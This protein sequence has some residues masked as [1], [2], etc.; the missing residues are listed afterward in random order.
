MDDPRYP[1]G[2][3]QAP[4]TIDAEMRRDHLERIESL[5]L[6]LRNAVVGLDDA[7]L[8]TPY[9]EGGWTLRQVVHHVADSHMNA[10]TRHKLALTEE[11]PT[12]RPYDQ[13]RWAEL[14]DA[15]TAPIGM[16]LAMLDAIHARWT[17]ML[18]ALAPEHFERR[19]HH[20]EMGKTIS[21]DVNLA[22]YA[23]H[24]AHHVAHIN[25]LRE[26]KGW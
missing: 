21:L 14:P 20:P 12:I 24:G 4:A 23:W 3:F 16:S 18:R 10:F 2:T 7:Q 6:D 22:L 17:H 19:F 1:I 25:R 8:D 5:P 15:R 9:R 26:R 13:T 11:T